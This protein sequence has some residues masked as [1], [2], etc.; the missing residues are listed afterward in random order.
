MNKKKRNKRLLKKDFLTEEAHNRLEEEL[1][2]EIDAKKAAF[3]EQLYNDI[4][5]WNL[6][7]G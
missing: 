7:T 1:Q 2:K 4:S 3:I 6:K 5:T